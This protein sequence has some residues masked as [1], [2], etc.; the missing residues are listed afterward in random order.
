MEY[1]FL[2]MLPFIGGIITGT[3]VLLWVQG[4]IAVCIIIYLNSDRVNRLELAGF[5]IVIPGIIF[6]V[7]MV[8]GDI[9]W[10]IQT[11][12]LS[13]WNIGNPFVVSK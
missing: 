9:S 13:E 8:I 5:L 7:G 3:Q 6:T 10:L 1:L 11:G 12:A 2:I 4:I